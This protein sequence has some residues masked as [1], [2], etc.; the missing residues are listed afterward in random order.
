MLLLYYLA[1]FQKDGDNIAEKKV[2][3][4]QNINTLK[5]KIEICWN[6]LESIFKLYMDGCTVHAIFF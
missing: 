3:L 5:L 4:H 6:H 1:M 2:K